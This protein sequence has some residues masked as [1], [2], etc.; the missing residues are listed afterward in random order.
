MEQTFAPTEAEAKA[1]VEGQFEE[2]GDG[3]SRIAYVNPD[4]TVV[5]KVEKSGYNGW[6]GTNLGEH[7]LATF[8]RQRQDLLPENVYIPRTEVFSITRTY[9]KKGGPL[10]LDPETNLYKREFEEEVTEP[11]TVIAMEY[12]EGGGDYSARGEQVLGHEGLGL[13]DMHADNY[14]VRASDGAYCPID[15][16]YESDKFLAK[17][18]GT[19]PPPEEA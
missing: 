7:Q 11:T 18:T 5:Y 10:V 13:R 14:R 3:A 9:V 4:Q 16:A 17:L 1:A 19:T 15:M 6:A 12:I 2:I 8:L